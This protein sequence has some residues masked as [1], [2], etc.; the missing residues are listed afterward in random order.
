MP[1][2]QPVQPHVEV[3]HVVHRRQ[4]VDPVSQ[5]G[6]ERGHV[7]PE[8]LDPAGPQLRV[9]ALPGDVGELEVVR[10]R[11]DQREAAPAR[12]RGQCGRVVRR[13]ARQPEPPD[14]EGNGELPDREV[15]LLP[16]DRPAAVAGHHQVGADL[17]LA[18]VRRP[19][20]HPA[21]PSALLHEPGHLG[22]HPQREGRLVPPGLGQQVQQVP[23]GHHRDVGVTHPQPA[24]VGHDHAVTGVDGEG[25][26]VQPA[27]RKARELL[28]QSQLVQE[29]Q[30][31]GVHR[32]TAEVAEEVAVLLQHAHLD[33]G[34]GKQQPQHHSGW[35]TPDN[36]AGRLLARH[37]PPPPRPR[38]G[39]PPQRVHIPRRQWSGGVRGRAR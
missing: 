8:A 20:A 13:L 17:A 2:P 37:V 28:P 16:S 29:L 38:Y 32:V 12:P 18:R 3:Q 39:C 7:P 27:L 22:A 10:A 9:T 34:S 33:A 1:A 31:R 35:P 30:G 36:H 5:V 19:V 23:L 14:V 6:H 4:G 15:C 25:H 26:L 24:E 21:H 11:D